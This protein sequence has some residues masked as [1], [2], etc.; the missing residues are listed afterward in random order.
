MWKMKNRINI[1]KFIIEMIAI[2]IVIAFLWKISGVEPTAYEAAI[3]AILS[4][5]Y[6]E[7]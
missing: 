4:M 2:A 1:L 7:K 6:F 3:I 5:I